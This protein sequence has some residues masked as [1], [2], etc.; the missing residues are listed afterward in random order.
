MTQGVEEVSGGLRLVL[1]LLGPAL[2]AWQSS[3]RFVGMEPFSAIVNDPRRGSLFLFWHNRIFPVMA[4]YRQVA[5]S[6]RDL[7]ALV[8][9]SRDGAQFSHFLEGC[10]IRTVRGSSSRRGSVAA[11]ELLRIVE[12]GHHVAISV[13]GP[14]G[15]CYAAQPGAALLLQATGISPTLI[16]AE[17][18]HGRALSSWD[19]FIVPAPGSRVLIKMDRS[20]PP[21]SERGK[22]G[23]QA[24]QKWIQEKLT[25]LTTDSHRQW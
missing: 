16:G 22:E 17:V 5:A 4:G 20:A 1:G 15:P 14:R 23:R 11:R 6:G 24:V 9:A 25:S 7:Y 10:G 18:E 21:A 19:Q 3:F 8:S 13:D 12:D 2:K